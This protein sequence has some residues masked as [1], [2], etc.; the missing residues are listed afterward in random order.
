[1]DLKKHYSLRN[2]LIW[3]FSIVVGVTYFIFLLWTIYGVGW[4]ILFSE[5]HKVSFSS[6]SI[7]AMFLAPLGAI[8][9][10]YFD[11]YLSSKRDLNA[12]IAYIENLRGEIDRNLL[13]IEK[14]ITVIEEYRNKRMKP[15]QLMERLRVTMKR[16]YTFDSYK[17]SIEFINNERSK[18]FEICGYLQI[19]D[20]LQ[21]YSNYQI[22]VED[23]YRRLPDIDK[24]KEYDSN[25]AQYEVDDY[26]NMIKYYFK[27]LEQ[28]KESVAKQVI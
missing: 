16:A 1:M 24:C 6:A 12:K 5:N 27:F 25:R 15:A 7:L 17:L 18:L 20:I 10:V 3:I 21:T 23:S 22:D 2:T 19:Y 9:A 11:R 26:L 4:E 13:K 8:A 28:H 14:I